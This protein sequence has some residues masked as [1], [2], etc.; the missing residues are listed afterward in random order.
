MFDLGFPIK[1]SPSKGHNFF[2]IKLH[3]RLVFFLV[4]SLTLRFSFPISSLLDTKFS[5]QLIPDVRS[6]NCNA[7]CTPFSWF[8]S[9][10]YWSNMFV[11]FILAP[12]L[13]L[14][15]SNFIFPL[16]GFWIVVELFLFVYLRLKAFQFSGLLNLC[17]FRGL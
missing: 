11:I 12:I 4:L 7:K 15:S 13:F 3:C 6:C 14:R 1:I 2:S 10:S 9:F 5:P 16:S 17:Q 8:N